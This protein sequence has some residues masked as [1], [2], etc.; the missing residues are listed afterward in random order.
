MM[1]EI[2]SARDAGALHYSSR[3]NELGHEAWP[4]WLLLAAQQYDEHWLAY[5]LEQ[6]EAMKHLERRA[7][8]GGYTAA[9]VP[10]T[11]AETLSDGQFNRYYIAAIC[12]R[13]IEDGISNVTVYRAKERSEPRAE[14]VALDGT[15]RDATALLAEV[16]SKELSLQCD[17]LKP[18]SGLSVT[19]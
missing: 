3:F 17:L 1:D 9:H 4:G 10:D 16:R 14:S 18:N 13:A 6:M 2:N 8:L 11:A 7:R 5:Q 15:Q 19:Y 12:R